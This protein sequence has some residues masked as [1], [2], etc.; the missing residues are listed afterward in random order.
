MLDETGMRAQLEALIDES[1]QVDEIVELIKERE[2]INEKKQE[3]LVVDEISSLKLQMK[4]AD[5]WRKKAS[6]AAQIISKKLST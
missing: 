4:N 5:N 6:L 1:G 3:E 2:R